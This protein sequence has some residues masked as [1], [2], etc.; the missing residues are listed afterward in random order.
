MPPPCPPPPGAPFRE[1]HACRKDAGAHKK[2]Q[3]VHEFG[4]KSGVVVSKS[5]AEL[6]AR[7]GPSPY[8]PPGGPGLH[9]LPWR[10]LSHSL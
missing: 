8:S 2:Q 7:D 6:L 5:Y 4:A 1:F 3:S 9:C 10:A